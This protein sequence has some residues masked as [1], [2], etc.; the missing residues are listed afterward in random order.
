MRAGQYLRLDNLKSFDE[1]LKR[2][3]RRGGSVLPDVDSR[4]PAA[5]GEKVGWTG[6]ELAKLAR[7]DRQHFDC[8]TWLHRAR[9]MPKEQFKQE[10]EKE[11]TGGETE[12]WEIVHFKLYQ[13][14]IPVIDRAIEI[15]SL[16]VGNNKS[17]GYCLEIICA[18]FLAGTN[19]EH[20]NPACYC[21]RPCVSFG[22]FRA[23]KKRRSWTAWLSGRHEL[24]PTEAA[25]PAA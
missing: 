8:A 11:L 9:E 10:V 15:A 19:L 21:S 23:T 13:R 22:F 14:Q 1:F 17:R 7:R 2:Q 25:S 24:D 20:N 18:D 16:M 4:T 12:P 3:F 5:T 6:L